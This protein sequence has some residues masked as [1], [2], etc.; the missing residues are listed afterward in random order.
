[1]AKGE[2]ADVITLGLLRC[3]DY[4]ELSRWVQCN[5]KVLI[6]GGRRIRVGE[7]NIITKARGGSDAQKRARDQECQQPLE[8][9]KGKEIDSP[10]KR[11]EGTQPCQLLNFRL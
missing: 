10:L 4:L 9:A 2:S 8:A 11:P 1:M 3:K 5:Y 7:G 6:R